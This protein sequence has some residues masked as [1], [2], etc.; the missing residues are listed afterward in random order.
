MLAGRLTY[1]VCQFGVLAALVN[2]GS[3]AAAGHFVLGLAVTAPVVM[4]CNLQLRLVLA[5]DVRHE[6][7]FADYLAVRNL[8][9]V[10]ALG[11]ILAL[12]LFAESRQV[13]VIIAAVGVSKLI[14]SI[15]DIHYGRLQR[16]NTTN[17]VSR[18]LFIRGVASFALATLACLVFGS[19]V[20]VCAALSV[21][22]L[23]VL[24]FHDV[25]ASNSVADEAR[26]ESHGKRSANRREQMLALV[27]RGLPLA[28]GSALMSLEANV[29]RYVV[30]A[31]F[32]A[33]VLAVVGVM[34]YALAIGQTVVSALCYPAVPRLATYYADGNTRAFLQL[35]GKLV[36]LGA[37]AATLALGAAGLFGRPFLLF[38]MGEEFAAHNTLMV[39]TVAAG[40]IQVI[41][42]ILL[43]ALRAMR[44]FKMVSLIQVAWLVT[45]AALCVGFTR[46]AGV[47]GVGWALVASFSFGTLLCAGLIYFSIRGD[48][49]PC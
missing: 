47:N 17:I 30:A 14:E 29:P 35:S 32:D 33:N 7:P 48:K 22:G 46:H 34:T 11:L 38:V 25:P 15:S 39:I 49:R 16:A 45:T 23:A 13:A 26:C 28:V 37:F 40:G 4:F 8:M 9:A 43:N 19:V 42:H 36:A 12:A 24:V 27:W 10:V 20:A 2:L 44:R 6:V 3:T 1:I 41:Q 21:C 31:R 18:S 5:T